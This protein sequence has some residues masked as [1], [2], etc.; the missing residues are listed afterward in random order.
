[1]LVENE[2]VLEK[3]QIIEVETGQIVNK[4]ELK[5]SYREEILN[6]LVNSKIKLEQLGETLDIR[7]IQDRQGNN[8]SVLNVKER[9]HFVK[10]FKVDIRGILEE[11]EL[12]IFARGFLYSCLA[13]L[14]FPTNTLLINGETPTNEIL[15]EKFKIGKTK[16]YDVY[17]ELENADILKRK[18]INGQMI[19]YLKPFL[20]S[21]GLVDSETYDIFKSSLYNPINKISE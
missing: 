7:I 5:R 17:K 2:Y 13:Y 12:S 1:M 16:L 4:N 3:G 6:S 10:V 18:K 20:H 14:N 9:Y 21:C 19:I 8:H 15:C 11:C